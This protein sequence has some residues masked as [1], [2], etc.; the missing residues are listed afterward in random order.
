MPASLIRKYLEMIRFSHTLFALPFALLAAGMAWYLNA[1]PQAAGGFAAGTNV[2]IPF[3]WL[4]LAGI[5]L[6]MVFARSAAMAFNRLADRHIDAKNPRT[7]GRHLPAGTLSVMGVIAFTVFCSAGFIG[8]TL[9]FLPGNPFPLISSV[10]VLLLLFSY[11]LMKRYTVFV[12]FFL[13][14]VLMLAPLAAWVAIRGGYYVMPFTY[15][16]WA[17]AKEASAISSYIWVG[18]WSGHMWSWPELSPLLLTAAVFFW[19]A[20]FDIIY[21]CM[22]TDFDRE[23]GVFSIP[24]RL[25]TRNALRI[26]AGCHLLVP[27]PLLALCAVF[28]PF[29]ILWALAVGAITLLLIYEHW[30]VDPRDPARVNVAFFYVNAVI[31]VFLLAAG[32]AEMFL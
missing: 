1:N 15:V 29:G 21:A 8:S 13:G 16:T 6:A 17:P 22:D 25:G 19:S 5:L 7:A 3:R 12:H 2:V 28:P 26:A 27:I 32:M 23:S 24:G 18:I 9:L 30:I 11:S 14:M 20:G 10:P 4:D 31:S